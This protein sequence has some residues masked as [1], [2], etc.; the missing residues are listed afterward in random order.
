MNRNHWQE[1]DVFPLWRRRTGIHSL[2]ALGFCGWVLAAL[3]LPSFASA[4]NADPKEGMNVFSSKGCVRCHSLLGEGGKVGPDLSRVPSSGD[5]LELAAAMWSHG[6]LMWDRMSLHQIKMPRF[7]GQEMEDLFAY[8]SIT[9]SLDEPGNVEAGLQ[10]FQAKRCSDCHPIAGKGPRVGPDLAN[11]ASNRNG[12]GWTAA[13]WNHAPR[14]FK[15]FSAKGIPFPRF[16]DSQMA[17]LRAYVRAMAGVQSQ[18]RAYYRY[19]RP[20]SADQGETLFQTK[21]CVQCHSIGGHGGKVGPDLSRSSFPANYSGIAMT[22]WNHAPEM[23]RVM[24][25][26]SIPP[27]QFEVQ[28]FADLLAYLSTLSLKRPGDA[29]LGA[30]NFAAKG[31]SGCHAVKPGLIS[32]G[33]NLTGLQGNLTAISIAGSMWNH[34]PAMLKRM[35]KSAISW[36][37][38]KGKELTDILAFLKSIQAKSR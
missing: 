32:I 34:G 8:L 15:A 27:P 20:P 30:A 16:K 22:I 12:V 38:F 18:N 14:M 37:V 3:L 23:Q 6:P 28:E 10:V 5:S 36:P 25:T 9:A 4:R 26:L 33:P 17:D 21:R 31:C 13:M 19:L 11:V 2:S 7:E 29:T 24:S 35:E 1:V